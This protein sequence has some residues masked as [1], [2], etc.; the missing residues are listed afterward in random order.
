[1]S[2]SQY[3]SWGRYPQVNQ[4]GVQLAWRTDSLPEISDEHANLL[5]WGNGRSYGDVC[6]N[7]GGL[8][9]GTRALC[10]LLAFDP[11]TGIV[12]IEA[13]VTLAELLQLVVPAGW[14]LPVTPGTAFVTAGGALAND[15][16]GK[17]HHLE[18]TFG[19][20]VR[21]F[22]L[23]RSDGSRLHCSPTENA[24][25]FA[26]TIGGM[27]LT[28]LVTWVEIQLRPI[29]GPMLREESIR[30]ANVDEFFRLSDGSDDDFEY[31]V[32]WVDCLASGDEAGRGLFSRANHV[33]AQHEDSTDLVLE[34]RLSM[35]FTPPF[36]L[37]N[38]LSLRAFNKLWYARQRKR[39]VQKNTHFSG[40][41]YPL[42]AIGNWNRMY[43]PRGM[44]QYQCVL[45]GEAGRDAIGE[46]LARITRSGQGSFLAV[47]KVFGDKASPGML[48]FPR[49][50]VTLALDFPNRPDVFRL[51]D[52]LDAVTLEAGG[53]VYP[54]KDARM[55]AEV[56]RAGFPRWQK[57]ANYIDPNFSSSF[58][59][60]VADDGPGMTAM[61]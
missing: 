55:K 5:P 36:S 23:L 43:G 26:A 19:C 35:P 45:P 54:A 60:R 57:F 27:G 15:V 12:R 56:F 16:H 53:A 34:P 21:A 1:M 24:D 50:G 37:V 2:G 18:G 28:G 51:L 10:H 7:R 46:M 61:D 29:P 38:N 39:R 20:H 9:I 3:T 17:N 33:D 8:V 58:W 30:Y 13:G 31:T 32:S 48:S 41:F 49:P 42:D 6:L 22:E 25:Y 40:F 44:L 11:D 14:F 47:L 52:Q 59:R 4:R